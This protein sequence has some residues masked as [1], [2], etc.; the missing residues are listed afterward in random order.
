MYKNTFYQP[1]QNAEELFESEDEGYEDNTTTTEV[2]GS[3]TSTD[4]WY[5]SIVTDV[6]PST[7]KFTFQSDYNIKIS[8]DPIKESE[9]TTN[10]SNE[11]STT[12]ESIT[13]STEDGDDIEDISN[14]LNSSLLQM[15]QVEKDQ[16]FLIPIKIIIPSLHMHYDKENDKYLLYENVVFKTDD[17]EYHEHAPQNPVALLNEVKSDDV[18]KLQNSSLALNLKT[19]FKKAKSDK[20]YMNSYGNSVFKILKSYNY[21]KI[22]EL[23]YVDFDVEKTSAVLDVKR[24]VKKHYE[25]LKKWLGWRFS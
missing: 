21:S 16:G 15:M 7:E 20:I 13:D 6:A 22:T 14:V 4:S 5:N 2:Y 24:D 23:D 9:D 18:S 3:E 19:I 25:L 1:F 11:Y 8:V 12:T 17:S 10:L